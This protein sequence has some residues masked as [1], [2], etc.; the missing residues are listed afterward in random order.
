M[1]LIWNF[2]GTWSWSSTFILPTFSFPSYWPASS[3]TAGAMA[4]QG[5]HQ[6]GITEVNYRT[7]YKHEMKALSAAAHAAGAVGCVVNVTP[8][9]TAA[10]SVAVSSGDSARGLIP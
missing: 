7:G 8:G 6:G 10:R 2:C 3:S 5:P 1:L 9:A 4:R